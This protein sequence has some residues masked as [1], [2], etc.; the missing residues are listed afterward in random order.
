MN[1]G[2]II[3]RR[4]LEQLELA[5]HAR[6]LARARRRRAE[7]PS[8]RSETLRNYELA[9]LQVAIRGRRV[10]TPCSCGASLEAN[11]V[12]AAFGHPDEPLPTGEAFINRLEI[13]CPKCHQMWTMQGEDSE[14]L[15]RLVRP[16]LLVG[17][18]RKTSSKHGHLHLVP[19]PE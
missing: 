17:G 16:T 1:P 7:H 15:Q 4:H 5:Q 12:W 8:C 2:N 11:W 18:A 9:N 19:T 3:Y 10:L 13:E 6:A 14:E